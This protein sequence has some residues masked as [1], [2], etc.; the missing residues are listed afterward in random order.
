MRGNRRK[1][2]H[3]GTTFQIFYFAQRPHTDTHIIVYLLEPPCTCT[4]LQPT[5]QHASAIRPNK[6][7]GWI[8]QFPWK[9]KKGK[10]FPEE[11]VW[12]HS[13]ESNGLVGSFSQGAQACTIPSKFLRS[14][15]TLGSWSR[16]RKVHIHLCDI[17]IWIS[18]V[19][20]TESLNCVDRSSSNG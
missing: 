19:L 6:T 10:P 15:R 17:L 1:L 13:S 20:R 11:H 14:E 2:I 5:Q 9:A 4:E 12:S 7:S 8:F 3:W 16:S 18:I